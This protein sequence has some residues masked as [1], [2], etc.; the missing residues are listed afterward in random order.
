MNNFDAP[1]PGNCADCK[2][3]N[4]SGP[5]GGECREGPPH[6]TILLIPQQNMAQRIQGQPPKITPQTLGAFPPV[7]DD[8]WCWRFQAKIQLVS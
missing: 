5:Q 6:A 8:T 4:R 2:Y 7:M 3:F 1:V